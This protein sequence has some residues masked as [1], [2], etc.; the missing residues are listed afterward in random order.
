MAKTPDF[1]ADA[2]V[3][4]TEAETGDTPDGEE[5]DE[6]Q[7]QA[8]RTRPFKLSRQ[9][10]A[11]A[12]HANEDFEVP[13]YNVWKQQTKTAGSRHFGNSEVT[14][15]DRL[16]YLYT[17]PF[18]LVIDPFGGGG[19]TLEVCR[20]RW[21]R[22]FISD[23]KP[24][25]ERKAEIRQHD[26]TEGLPKPPSWKDVK[27][28]YLDPPYWKQAEGRYSE[29]PTDLANM[30]LDR[31]HDALAKVVS[32]FAAKLA[33]CRASA[34]IALIIQPTQWKAPNRQFTDHAAE[35]IRRVKYPLAQ[36][37][38]AP[39]ES[40]QCTAQMVEWA[41]ENRQVLVLSREI[42]VWKVG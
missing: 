1:D 36:R 21:R 42:V 39:Y 5:I 32:D 6:A 34:H 23:R 22:C 29:D 25:I 20:K 13:V 31:F 18:D 17:K 40:Q 9:Q 11:N 26:L 8:L 38:Q 30:D 10:M 16:L 3:S 19:S 24:V 15:V 27:L 4:E 12:E 14:W 2:E 7:L 33:Q 41:K 28:V 37:I 35:M